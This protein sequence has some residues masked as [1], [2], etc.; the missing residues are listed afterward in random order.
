MPAGGK[1]KPRGEVAVFFSFLCVALSFAVLV[2][3]F[4]I[5]PPLENSVLTT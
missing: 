5:G 3:A 2:F 4:F 1:K